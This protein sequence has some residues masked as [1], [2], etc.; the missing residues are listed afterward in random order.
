M[1]ILCVRDSSNIA[2]G[3]NRPFLTDLWHRSMLPFSGWWPMLI[4][5]CSR[6]LALVAACPRPPAK[7]PPRKTRV[8]LF[9]ERARLV[10]SWPLKTPH[11]DAASFHY[12]RSGQAFL[13]YVPPPFPYFF[14]VFQVFLVFLTASFESGSSQLDVWLLFCHFIFWTLFFF[15]FF[16]L[17]LE[18]VVLQLFLNFL[19]FPSNRFVPARFCCFCSYFLQSLL[20][21]YCILRRM[22]KNKA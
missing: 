1:V 7:P 17:F 21:Y 5:R 19:L 22:G 16:L 13:W 9:S 4:C 18:V 11:L 10:H 20:F 3:N 6:T 14:L 2:S 15:F 12:V 8:C